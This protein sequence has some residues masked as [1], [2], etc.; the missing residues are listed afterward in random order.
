M[1]GNI[2][3]YVLS[4]KRE[5]PDLPASRA[6]VVNHPQAT[7]LTATLGSPAEL[8]NPIRAGDN[9]ARFGSGVQ[10]RLEL[11]IFIVIEIPLEQLA[12]ERRLDE[13]VHR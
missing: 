13:F 3:L 10:R 11:S 8:S 12:E 6:K 4:V 5:H 2:L 7:A 1:P 9:G